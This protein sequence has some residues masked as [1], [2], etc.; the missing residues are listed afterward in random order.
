ML[1][2]IINGIFNFVTSDKFYLPVIFIG[3]GILSYEI[4]S[5]TII[6]V[7]KINNYIGKG[8]KKLKTYELLAI[9]RPNMDSEEVDSIV[10]TLSEL[11]KS[12]NGEVKNISKM[13]RKKLA[14]EV[15]KFRDAYFTAIQLSIPEQKVAEFKRQL[16][17]N[18]AIIRTMF[19]EVSKVGV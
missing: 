16:R 15:Q 7:S 4:V 6:K 12:Y 19:M 10:D 3:I 11:V 5:K 13:G 9:I 8:D 2:N 14:Y 17:L 18:D 1:D